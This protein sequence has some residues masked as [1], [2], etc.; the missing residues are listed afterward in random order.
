VHHGTIYRS[1]DHGCVLRLQH[2]GPRIEA[3]FGSY[4]IAGSLT[5]SDL[6]PTTGSG[7]VDLHVTI[8]HEIG[9]HPPDR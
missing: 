1:P 9:A 4:L 5:C 6:V 8:H 3:T 2:L 7:E